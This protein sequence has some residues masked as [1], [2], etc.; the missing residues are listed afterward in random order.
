[1]S[2]CE[3]CIYKLFNRDHGDYLCHNEKSESWGK[4]TRDIKE[5]CPLAQPMRTYGIKELKQV[6]KELTTS[7]IPFYI[8]KMPKDKEKPAIIISFE[9][10]NEMI[11]WQENLTELFVRYMKMADADGD[12]KE[13]K[14][15]ESEL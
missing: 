12:F 8:Y 7:F 10:N 15:D 1:M 2:V 14:K 5:K 9:S 11:K 3:G 13:E 4:P 6:F